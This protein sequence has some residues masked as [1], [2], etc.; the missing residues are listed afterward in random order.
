MIQTMPSALLITEIEHS[1]PRHDGKVIVVDVR[2]VK[3]IRYLTSRAGMIVLSRTRLTDLHARRGN[4]RKPI[5]AVG[6]AGGSNAIN[7]MT[8]RE[9][10]EDTERGG[11]FL[12]HP[13]PLIS[14]A[15]LSP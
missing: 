6:D 11:P 8:R 7:S 3:N 12:L 2:I 14:A 4:H 15:F 9:L 10:L 5:R 13:S 1:L